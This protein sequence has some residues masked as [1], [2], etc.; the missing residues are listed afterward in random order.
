V[1]WLPTTNAPDKGRGGNDGP[2]AAAK[3]KK[4]KGKE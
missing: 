2:A 3:Q 1:K 4:K